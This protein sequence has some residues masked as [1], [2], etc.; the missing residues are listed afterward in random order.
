ARILCEPFLVRQTE[1]RRF[2][3]SKGVI[4]V[5]VTIHEYR[6]AEPAR[7]AGSCGVPGV[8]WRAF[9]GE[10][11][12]P[13]RTMMLIAV[14]ELLAAPAGPGKSSGAAWPSL[15]GVGVCVLCAVG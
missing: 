6:H 12:M 14:R 4:R 10:G 15:R 11:I 13:V 9:S 8:S 7:H 2:E 3:E 1:E 5:R